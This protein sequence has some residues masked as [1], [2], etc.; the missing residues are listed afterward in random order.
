MSRS[1]LSSA[2][3]AVMLAPFFASS[4]RAGANEANGYNNAQYYGQVDNGVPYNGS[5]YGYNYAPTYAPIQAPLYPCPKPDVPLEVGRTIITNPAFAPHE[6]LYP[7]CYRALYPPYYVCNKG[8]L[9]C[10]PFVPKPPLR[11]TEVKVRYSS[12]IGLFDRFYPPISRV[13]YPNGSWNTSWR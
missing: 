5:Y 3:V 4:A 8:G 2:V 6:M 13:W 12:H 9:A 1:L 7:H 11:G 10:L